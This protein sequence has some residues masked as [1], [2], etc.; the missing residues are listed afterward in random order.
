MKELIR[1]EIRMN[2]REL[3]EMTGK[4]HDNVMA[5]IRNEM[6]NLENEGEFNHLIFEEAKYIDSKGESRPMYEFGREGAMQIALR[7]S[8]SIRRKII[9]KLEELEKNSKKINFDK[10]KNYHL[11]FIQDTIE[12]LKRGDISVSA[13]K[14][15]IDASK[16]LISFCNEGK[17]S[18]TKEEKDMIIKIAY[19]LKENE[20]TF[21]DRLTPSETFKLMTEKIEGFET[22]F[23]NVNEFTRK[24]KSSNFLGFK[25]AKS[26]G[27]RRWVFDKNEI[28]KY[29]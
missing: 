27:K 28:D 11:N 7:Y 14:V 24:M 29:A 20:G 1:K 15:I 17:V 21:L 12:T 9:L 2:S 16:Y 8:A 5:D 23:K 22:E 13:S 6:K 19:F 18:D 26:N 4:R 25:T 10:D 3:A